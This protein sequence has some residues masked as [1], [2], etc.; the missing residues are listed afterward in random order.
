[1]YKKMNKVE[2]KLESEPKRSRNEED[3]RSDT[4]LDIKSLPTLL[5]LF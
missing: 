4:K 5:C 1:M 2:S 3:G